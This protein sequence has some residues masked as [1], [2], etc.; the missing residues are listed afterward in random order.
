MGGSYKTRG[1]NSK[2]S[3][4]KV[5]S[6]EEF[7]EKGQRACSPPARIS[8]KPCQLLQRG[9]G[10]SPGFKRIFGYEKALKMSVADINFVRFILALRVHVHNIP[11]AA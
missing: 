2:T 10:R 6:G 7:L 3:R 8:G 9:P 5:K 11:C 4:S 1:P